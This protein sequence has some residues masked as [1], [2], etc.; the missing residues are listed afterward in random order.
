MLY[1][2][3]GN[4][5]PLGNLVTP[6]DRIVLL[7]AARG[8]RERLAKLRRLDH[9]RPLQLYRVRP[10]RRQPAAAARPGRGRA[11]R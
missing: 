9:L 1:R 11:R 2:Q 5:P 6:A 10:C 3:A 7:T 4:G 8:H